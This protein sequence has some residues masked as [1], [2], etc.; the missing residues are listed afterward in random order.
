MTLF[1]DP[2]PLR[3]R[4]PASG[5]MLSGGK[6]GRGWVA[7]LCSDVFRDN[8]SVCQNDQSGPI[9]SLL[10]KFD[11]FNLNLVNLYVQ[12]IPAER[13]IFFQSVPSFLLPNSRLL[14]GGDMNCFDSALDKWVGRFPATP[15]SR[16]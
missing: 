14:I 6:G 1:C 9:F 3:G 7:I 13:N 16:T 11:E 2:S 10:V 4:A 5:P 15:A 12:T 8:V